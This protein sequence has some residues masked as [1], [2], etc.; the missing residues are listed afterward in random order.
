MLHETEINTEPKFATD[1]IQND[2]TLSKP[3]L[4]LQDPPRTPDAALTPPISRQ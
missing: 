2:A 1:L 3:M 4:V